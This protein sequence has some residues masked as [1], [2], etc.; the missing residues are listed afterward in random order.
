VK[1]SRR[2]A[3]DKKRNRSKKHSERKFSYGAKAKKTSPPKKAS[4]STSSSSSASTSSSS[5]SSS[6]ID[7]FKSFE[8]NE[9]HEKKYKYREVAPKE[10]SGCFNYKLPI[11]AII[12]IAVIRMLM[13]IGNLTNSTPTKKESPFEKQNA[14]MINRADERASKQ[15][16]AY[17][18]HGDIRPVREVAQLT[19]DSTFLITDHVKVRLFKGFRLHRTSTLP[20]TRMFAKYSK[21]YFSYDKVSVNPNKSMTAHWKAL[22]SKLLRR[23]N[24]GVFSSE[25]IKSYSFKGLQIEEKE[26]K[27]TLSSLELH[28]IATLVESEGKRYFFHFIAQEKSGT[29][30]R[31]AYLKKYMNFYLKIR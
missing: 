6:S 22:R 30:F 24:E 23:A 27:I 4:S 12:I 26:F 14:R 20:T 25:D 3:Y 21:Y 13:A 16:T 17:L 29:Y 7:R 9:Q 31:R 15:L 18:I 2:S 1:R 28:G 11:A 10:R 8:I 5:S 19:K